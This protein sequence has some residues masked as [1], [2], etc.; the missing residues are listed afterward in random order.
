MSLNETTIGTP[1]TQASLSRLQVQHFTPQGAVLPMPSP[2]PKKQPV[3]KAQGGAGKASKAP[4]IAPGVQWFDHLAQNP[5]IDWRVEGLDGANNVYEWNGVHWALVNDLA[6]QSRALWYL[7]G[8]HPDRATRANANDA[9]AVVAGLMRDTQPLPKPVQSHVVF[10]LLDAYLH[11]DDRGQNCVKRPEKA[12]GLTHAAQLK[13]GLAP[14]LPYAPMPVPSHSQFAKY[15]ATSL[16]DLEVRALVQEQCA[17]SFLPNKYQQAAWWV[18][19]GG[20]GKGTLI[21]LLMRL[22]SKVA[23]VDLHKLDDSHS[24]EPLVGASVVIIDEVTTKGTWGEKAFKSLVS[25][26]PV[27]INPKHKKGF[28]YC[29]RAYWIIASNQE[30]LISDDSSGVRRRVVP[31]P[32]PSSEAAIG[33]HKIDDLDELLFREE[34]RVFLD[35]ILEGLQR[36]IRRGGP[37]RRDALPKAVRDMMG[38]LHVQNDTM[39]AW[40]RDGEVRFQGGGQHTSAEIYEHYVKTICSRNGVRWDGDPTRRPQSVFVLDSDAFW[41][42]FRRRPDVQR[43]FAAGHVTKIRPTINGERVYV[44]TGIAIKATEQAAALEAELRRDIE[45]RVNAEGFVF[46][47]EPLVIDFEAQAVRL[48]PAADGDDDPFTPVVDAL[49]GQG[50]VVARFTPTEV[51]RFRALP[52]RPSAVSVVVPINGTPTAFATASKAPPP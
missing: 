42:R 45:Q 48:L 24:L 32:W 27:A 6:G 40:V 51:Q 8:N 1:I 36:I 7:K 2:A 39:E 26:D 25:G 22:H 20:G 37:V 34:P 33:S 18:G 14:G 46:P 52:V 3:P 23:T 43:A 12:L 44:Y 28:T 10:P 5:R 41:K 29:S 47:D 4:K 21:K 35:W 38:D 31:V 16:P 9:W 49:T 13:I 11:V 15:L 50:M 19:D 17:L 30:P